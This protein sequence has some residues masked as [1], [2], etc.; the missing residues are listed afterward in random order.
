MSGPA[1]AVPLRLVPADPPDSAER[2]APAAA[3]GALSDAQHRLIAELVR[4][5]PVLAELGAKF[6]AAGHQLAL[7]GGP[8]RDALL[9]RPVQDL[10]F[11]TDARPEQILAVLEPLA[12]AT[13]TTGIRFGTVGARIGSA[14]CEVT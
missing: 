4:V 8:V 12:S 14:M 13:W 9:G 3:R 10:D 2:G 1:T 11:T 6:A 5:E 7:V